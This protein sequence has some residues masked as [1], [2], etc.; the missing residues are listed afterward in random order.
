MAVACAA[1]VL[2][3]TALLLWVL[4][5]G[6]DDPTPSTPPISLPTPGSDAPVPDTAT[7]DTAV[8][9]TGETST[10]LAGG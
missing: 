5:P 7:P 6:G 8:P 9:E 2:L 10:T 3:V 4:A 1:A